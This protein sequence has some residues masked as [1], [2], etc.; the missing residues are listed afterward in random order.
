[1]IPLILFVNIL[2]F[3][4]ICPWKYVRWNLLTE[5][6]SDHWRSFPGPGLSTRRSPTRWRPAVPKVFPNLGESQTPI[7]TSH[8]PIYFFRKK[9]NTK[10]S[11]GRG[12]GGSVARLIISPVE[13]VPE[14]KTSYLR[15]SPGLTLQ[16]ASW[17]MLTISI[18]AFGNLMQL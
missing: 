8:Q 12:L 16:P 2:D 1:M 13:T 14:P 9:K 11:C 5:A 15:I 7:D 18:I 10:H 17:F 6:E 4:Q 3:L